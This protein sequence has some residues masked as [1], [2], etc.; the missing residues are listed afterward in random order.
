MVQPGSCSLSTC[1]SG[2][3]G[4]SIFPHLW[5]YCSAL[6]S[7]CRFFLGPSPLGGWLSLHQHCIAAWSALPSSI[8]QKSSSPQIAC[9][10]R[11]SL[12]LL[13]FHIFPDSYQ[14][15]FLSMQWKF[16]NEVK[17]SEI[18]GGSSFLSSFR[19]SPCALSSIPTALSLFPRTASV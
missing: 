19:A 12:L 9:W 7:W 3:W 6:R 11:F 13:S 10:S 2:S 17:S 16:G 5:H 15:N 1:R 14:S 18:L 8:V 4:V